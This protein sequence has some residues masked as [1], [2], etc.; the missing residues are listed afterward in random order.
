MRSTAA[1]SSFWIVPV[2]LAVPIRAPVGRE[3][4]TVKA[5]SV[6]IWLSPAARMVIVF[7]VSFRAK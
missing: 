5:S 6:S 3:S 4:V 2:A 7:E 1:E